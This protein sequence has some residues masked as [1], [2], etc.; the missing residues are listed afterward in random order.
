MT[1]EMNLEKL[2]KKYSPLVLRRCFYILKDNEKAL[3]AMQDT[4]IQILKR[5]KSIQNVNLSG[6]LYK[7]ATNICLNILKKQKKQPLL[8]NEEKY[9]NIPFT[10]NHEK[11]IYANEIINNIFK[12]EKNST[13]LIATLRYIDELSLVQTAEIVGLSVSGVRRRLRK[14]KEKFENAKLN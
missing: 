7:T 12:R 2:Y 3:D 14:L 8:D 6:Y 1:F 10:D 5:K 4:F 13:K 11:I 9:L